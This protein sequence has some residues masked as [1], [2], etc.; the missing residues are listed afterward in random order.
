MTN[1]NLTVKSIFQNRRPLKQPNHKFQWALT[2]GLSVFLIGCESS[3]TNSQTALN[4][5]QNSEKYQT[6]PSTL[7]PCPNKANCVSSL[8]P[9]E[10]YYIAP[11]DLS[12]VT[13]NKQQDLM[14]RIKQTLRLMD[15][16]IQQEGDKY[17]H[18]VATSQI[19]QFKDDLEILI[20]EDNVTLH[21]KSASRLGYSD[22]GVNKARV[23]KLKAALLTELTD[24]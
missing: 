1:K 13:T 9:R 2:L 6:L 15:L 5:E 14:S 19:F 24:Q 11:L 3:P 20:S 21:F 23:E 22:F 12:L 17:L 4:A 8:D 18:A 7:E 10:S 16:D